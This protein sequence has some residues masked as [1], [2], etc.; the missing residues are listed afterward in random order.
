MESKDISKVVDKQDIPE[1]SNH[2]SAAEIVLDIIVDSATTKENKVNS[3]KGFTKT[4]VNLYYDT[5]HRLPSDFCDYL[6]LVTNS[7]NTGT[8]WSDPLI[9]DQAVKFFAQYD[10]E[11]GFQQEFQILAD[12]NYSNSDTKSSD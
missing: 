3:L 6:K 12:A 10:Y 1:R 4:F 5:L 9:K 11:I 7:I 2:P 8:L